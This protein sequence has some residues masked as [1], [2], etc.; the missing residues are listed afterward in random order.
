MTL[1][2]PLLC[3]M[4]HLCALLAAG[5]LLALLSSTVAAAGDDW[6]A[7]IGDATPLSRLSI[8]GSHDSCALRE[9]LAG[10]AK[11]QNLGLGDQLRSGVRFLD[12]RCK[13][14]GKAFT[15][16]HGIYDEGMT[17]AQVLSV[18]AGFLRS[19]PTETVIMSIKEEN[20]Q[21]GTAFSTLFNSY[22]AGN[23]ALWYLGS[24]VPT[25]GA[26]RGKIVLFRRF[27]G[28]E[29]IDAADWPDDT[30][31]AHG[32]LDVEDNYKVAS[33]DVK[34]ES[35]VRH[36]D[37]VRSSKPSTLSLTFTSGYVPQLFGIPSITAV[38]SRVNS[39]LAKYFDGAK[40]GRYG[41]VVMDFVD[42]AHC[43]QIITAN[44]SQPRMSF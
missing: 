2:R 9:P 25:L 17:F 43:G 40:P 41:I 18:A 3:P 42:R 29:G 33:A 38:S 26:V 13:N 8:P 12:I 19:N 11:C 27:Q 20:S 14:T 35:V 34:W 30:T 5:V 32:A 15:I 10:T 23:P 21:S 39:E 1:T 28:S 31:F 36:L 4:R 44:R 24:D 7:A 37:A 6:M 22:V 16:Y